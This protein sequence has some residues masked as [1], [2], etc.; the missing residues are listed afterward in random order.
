MIK[1]TDMKRID[2]KEY[3]KPELINIDDPDFNETGQGQS[4]VGGTIGGTV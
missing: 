2:R 3:K 1:E 4:C